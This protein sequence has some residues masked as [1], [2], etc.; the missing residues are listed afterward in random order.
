MAEK[1]TRA[2]EKLSF[3]CMRCTPE[4]LLAS[5]LPYQEK[6]ILDNLK[7]KH[8]HTQN[9]DVG[10]FCIQS[11]MCLNYFLIFNNR[12]PRFYKQEIL[13]DMII[14]IDTQLLSTGH[15]DQINAFLLP[16]SLMSGQGTWWSVSLLAP[17][18]M[19]KHPSPAHLPTYMVVSGLLFADTH[20]HTSKPRMLEVSHQEKKGPRSRSHPPS[21]TDSSLSAINRQNHWLNLSPEDDS[22]CKS[23]TVGLGTSVW[24]PQSP[25]LNP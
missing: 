7:N 9:E 10:I 6:R 5:F 2:H 3:S 19:S 14:D 17:K 18:E 24:V 11:N 23:H 25:F 8:T 16:Q 22:L 21:R 1:G 20:S 15:Q 4:L 13:R 12:F